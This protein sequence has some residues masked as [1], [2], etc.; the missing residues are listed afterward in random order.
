M[1]FNLVLLAK[2]IHYGFNTLV[3]SSNILLDLKNTEKIE[4]CS[5][6]GERRHSIWNDASLF[7]KGKKTQGDEKPK[8]IICEK[9]PSV[10]QPVNPTRESQPEAKNAS[11]FQTKINKTAAIQPTPKT[12]PVGRVSP[13]NESSK[14][15]DGVKTNKKVVSGEEKQHVENMATPL[16]ESNNTSVSLD[17]LAAESM[18]EA[19]DIEPSK[20]DEIPSN[21]GNTENVSISR[22]STRSVSR[23]L[24]LWQ[25]F[26]NLF[27]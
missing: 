24:I 2:F 9:P 26:F 17:H 25:F 19:A 4:E 11:T 27:I 7:T 21:H 5:N 1:V 22:E 23:S 15:S 16:T 14:S 6:D 12:K 18:L 13:L 10:E 3:S 8:E 20:D